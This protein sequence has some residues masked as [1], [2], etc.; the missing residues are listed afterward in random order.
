MLEGLEISEIK[1]S[2][3][4]FDN[5]NFRFDAQYFQKQYL[6]FLKSLTNLKPLGE[7]IE[8][9]YRVVYE[10]TH[11]IDKETGLGNNYPLFLQAADLKTPFIET[12]NLYYVHQSEWDRYQKGHIK[13]GELLIEVKGKIEKVAIVPDDFPEKVLV[14]GSVYKA[15]LK[16][17]ISKYYLLSYLICKYG[18]AFKER[19]KTNLLISFISKD[20]LYR[21]PVPKFSKEFDAEFDEIFHKISYKRN[22]SKEIYKKAELIL[23][24]TIGLTDFKPSTQNTNIKTFTQSFNASGRL[25]AEYY[26]PK[27]EDFLKLIF[28]FKH[29]WA[30]LTEI[31]TLKDINFNPIDEAE[32]KYIELADIDKSGGIT[33][34]TKDIGKNL[35]SRARRLVDKGDVVVSSIEGSLSSCA[36]VPGEYDKALCSTGFY[37]IKSAEINSE[38]LL[39]LIKSELMQNILKQN[40]SGTILT[41]LNKDEF[42]NLPIPRIDQPTQ[43]KISELVQQSFALKAESERLLNVA[44]RAVEIAIEKNEA[45]GLAFIEKESGVNH[46]IH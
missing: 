24:E 38:T 32:Y 25:D 29:G 3:V 21:I 26:Q 18:A 41:A 13:R 37:V 36:F 28:D 35:P 1:L 12:D 9:G 11:I 5:L 31:C 42:S 10:N 16:P 4:L 19:Y 23:L 46:A 45:A 40:C 15:A 27:Y 44:K 17:T 20:D 14:T 34:C 6:S 43:I 2:D 8:S 39:V 7:F 30:K 33:G 22:L